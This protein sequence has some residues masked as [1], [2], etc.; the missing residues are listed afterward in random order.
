MCEFKISFET[1]KPPNPNEKLQLTEIK[2]FYAC[3]Y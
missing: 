3:I 2:T 1:T